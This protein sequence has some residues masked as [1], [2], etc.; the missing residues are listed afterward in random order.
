[1][2]LP[3]PNSIACDCVENPF[4]NLSSELPD[5]FQFHSQWWA[6]QYCHSIASSCISQA[7]ADAKAYQDAILCE[8][9]QS[10]SAWACN[11]P[12]TVCA[13]CDGKNQF[14]EDIPPCQ[15]QAPTK[16]AAN[17]LA[18]AYAYQH[19][20]EIMF[21][22]ELADI[23]C[24]VNEAVNISNSITRGREGFTW[25]LTD[26]SLPAGLAMSTATN[27]RDI[28][29][30]GA[31][32]VAGVSTLT[33]HVTDATGASTDFTMTVTVSEISTGGALPDG[34]ASTPYSTQLAAVNAAA[35]SFHLA[36]GTLPPGLTMGTDGLIHGT[37]TTPGTYDFE[38][39]VT[40]P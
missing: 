26:G 10:G 18:T 14:C 25:S 32:T 38:V 27:G 11:D 4:Q 8:G 6:S 37:P 23:T 21:C 34:T 31:P 35:G 7:D 1:M 15:F 3:C 20:P 12:L 40:T 36:S 24:C 39:S 2:N 33:Y 28:S 29:F 22:C 30:S 16:E 5:C 9:D 17:A 13:D 19:I